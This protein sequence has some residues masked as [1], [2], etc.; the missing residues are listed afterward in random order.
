MAAVLSACNGGAGTFV[1]PTAAV[2]GAAAI[3]EADVV[4]QVKIVASQT[5]F[6]GLFTGPNS[7]LGRLDAKRQVL[8]QLVQQQAVVNQA[9]GL[10]VSVS[11]GDVQAAVAGTRQRLGGADAFNHTLAQH[12]ISL[13]DFIAYE[14]LNLT[15]SK[16]EAKVT[17][18]V[19]ASADQI[20]ASYQQNK[21]MYDSEYRVSHILICGHADANGICSATPADLTLADSVDQQAQ[22]GADF[23]TLART[24]S[25]D[26]VSRPA[27]GDLGWVA[28]G[29]AVP[30]FE[31]AALAL[32]PGQVTPKP[33]RTQF[34]YHIIKLIARGEP[35]ADASAAINSQLEQT[36]RQQAFSNWISQT[37]S[38]TRI[39]I[40][41]S[42]GDFD[43]TSQ[44]VVAPPGAAP[45]APAGGAGATG[46]VPGP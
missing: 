20:A 10:G 40:N 45:P 36:A 27:G 34:G 43:P 39:R 16:V 33:V 6:S 29:T 28:T 37:V 2:V 15:V 38:R 3:T 44:S 32:Q 14:R 22:G 41:P 24:Y 25:T 8:T 12:Q 31:Q 7:N 18:N 13:A 19:N 35:L 46:G 11:G 17:A 30:A 1:S 4:A 26:G 5:Q 21:A 23:A 42:Y 9:A